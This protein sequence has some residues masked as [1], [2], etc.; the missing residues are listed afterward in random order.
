MP[1]K[2]TQRMFL[3]RAAGNVGTQTIGQEGI[4]PFCGEADDWI[5]SI[6]KQGTFKDAEK[7]AQWIAVRENPASSSS[8][9]LGRYAYICMDMSGGMDGNLAALEPEVAGHDARLAAKRIRRSVRQVPIRL[10]PEVLDASLFKTY[11]R[12][13]KGFDSMQSLIKLTDGKGQDGND[14]ATRWHPDRKEIYGAALASNLVSDLSPFSLSVF[15]GGRYLSGSG[16]WTPYH[17]CWDSVVWTSTNIVNDLDAYV[18]GQFVS[19]WK[20][21]IEDAIYDYTHNV[22]VPKGLN[23]P[24]PKNVPMFNELALSCELVEKAGEIPGT[25]EYELKAKLTFEFWYPFPSEDNKRSDIYQVPAPTLGGSYASSGDQDL[26]A[27]M[28]MQGSSGRVQVELGGATPTPAT[29]SVPAKYNN[30]KPYVGT[31]ASNFVYTLPIVRS[32]G[33]TNPL[34]S[35]MTLRIQGV[36]V[37]KPIYLLESGGGTRKADMIPQ[38][39]SFG[40][41]NLTHGAPGTPQSRAVT[42]PRLNH[43]RGQWVNEGT[44]SIGE[45]NSWFTTS[46]KA[47]QD[48]GSCLYCRNGPMVTP[49]ELGFISV[50]R[51]W[52]TIDICRSQSLEMLAF[53]VADPN[54]YYG[55]RANSNAFYTNGTINPNTRSSNVLMSAF[56]DLSTHEVPNVDV[57]VIP[58]N[59][60]DE[61]TAA[62]IAKQILEMTE[63]GTM[64]TAFQAGTDWAGIP[65]MQKNGAL[66]RAHGLNNNQRESLIRNTWGLFSPGNSMF[67]VLVIAQTI[68]EGPNQVGI[69]GNDD[70]VTGERRLVAL[71]W[72]DPFKTGKNLHHEMFV[73]MVRYLND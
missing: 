8:R 62:L 44:G 18:G 19:G 34:P 67:T 35:G 47:F 66:A 53:L 4:E 30:G 72:R 48:E 21:W 46:P 1:V 27:R 15:R 32:G 2:E 28:I 7:H 9:I 26:W 73:K 5:P 39:I 38:D 61:D 64:D 3:S 6:Y 49:A 37:Q 23:Y 60:V 41:M 10:L 45:M 54:L 14:S 59:P 31:G 71:V 33:D 42:D 56:V 68:K 16:T 12:G 55:W 36:L 17:P 29:L 69:W 11:R 40:A 51:E 65:A 22:P 58:A 43:E 50:G 24:S 52:E 13:W 70:L 63:S 25:S 20:T 57:E